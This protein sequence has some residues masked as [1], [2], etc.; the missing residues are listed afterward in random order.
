MAQGLLEPQ[1]ELHEVRCCSDTRINRW[2]KRSESCPWAESDAGMGGCHSD[3]TFAEAEAI[4]IEAGARLCT[5]DE[6]EADCTAGTG[7]GHDRDLIWSSDVQTTPSADPLPPPPLPPPPSASPS[8]ALRF[9]E[10]GRVGNCAEPAGWVAASELHEVRC[11][12]DTRINRWSKRSESCPW[13]DSVD[14]MGG[15][16]SDKTFAEA[17]AICIE[18]GAR[19]CTKDELE[20]DCTAS[21][22]CGHDSD[23]IWSRDVP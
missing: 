18:A 9:V 10:C 12:S 23:L 19:L 2:S 3:K 13:A 5:K 6:L 4:C 17:E 11:C 22:G 21:T 14:G 15:C 7:C 8:T 20:A 1:G 16:H